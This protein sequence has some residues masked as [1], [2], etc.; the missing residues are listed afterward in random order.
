MKSLR[1]AY[2]IFTGLTA[3]LFALIGVSQLMPGADAVAVMQQ[4]GYPM[5]LSYVLGVC[6]LL[7]VVAILQPLSRELKEWAYAGMFFNLVF[8]AIAFGAIGHYGFGLWFPLILLVIVMT[9]YFLWKK[10]QT[11][12]A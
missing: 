12:T 2:W 1:I 5:Y 8:A 3:T 9:S 4:I 7:A 10:R 11:A 6:K